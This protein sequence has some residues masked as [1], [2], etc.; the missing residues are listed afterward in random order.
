MDEATDDGRQDNPAF[1][2]NR[3]PVKVEPGA[4]VTHAGGTY[5]ISEVVDLQTVVARAIET[6]RTAVLRIGELEPAATDPLVCSSD[7]GEFSE[8]DWSVA[9]ARYETIKPLIETIPLRR[10]D[11]VNR[12]AETG[13]DPATLYRWL[14]R[15]QAVGSQLALLPKARGWRAG[16]SRLSRDTENTIDRALREHYLKYQRSRPSKTV[17]EVLRR[18]DE[19]GVTP[20]SP[21]AIRR[22]I[23]RLPE[24]EVLRG[25]GYRERAKNK[26]SPA[27]GSFP[28]ADYPLSVIQIDHTRVDIVLVDDVHRLPVKPPWITLAIDVYSRVVTGYYLSF[29]D[30]SEASVAACI[31]HSMLP[32]EEWLLLHG[33]DGDWP[34][35]GIPAKVHVDNGPDFR[36]DTFRYSCA[37]YGIDLEYRPVKQPNYGGHIE[38]LLG[39]LMREIHDL[40]GTTFSSV[41]ERGDYDSERHAVM[42]ITEFEI[43]LVNLITKIYH[44]KKHSSL[45]MTPLRQWELGIFGDREKRGVGLPARPSD[46]QT[47]VL[48]FMPMFRRTIQTF[49]VSI[50]GLTYYDEA[51]R[52][53][54][55]ESDPKTGT[56]REFIFRRDPRDISSI[57]FF[58][59]TLK[60][61]C[62]IP[63]ADLSLPSM[64]K[65]E[66]QSAKER[67]REEG[68]ASVNP[69][70]LLRAVTEM[71]A[72]VEAASEKTKK[73][74]RQAQ[75]RREHERKLS[76]VKPVAL[77]AVTQTPSP[78]PAANGLLSGD[79]NGFEDIA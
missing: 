75:R 24:R 35:W 73:A 71:R 65:W 33:C 59:P 17:I 16:K 18:C 12:S 15:Y 40:P 32:K 69:Q 1:Q 67:V 13:R 27:A 57:W 19:L 48:D 58:D 30:P 41:K 56:K 54:I 29:D 52:P 72:Q 6:G 66:Y 34:V 37:A 61:Y 46:R 8:D 7:L 38:R 23:A 43:W 53:W 2:P 31:S 74:R 45:G 47:V 21:E 76:Q 14:R 36:S 70:E 63:S 42:T 77:A 11:V 62:R 4:L 39:T 55:N 50:E 22:R 64:S 9:Q 44:R 10:A 28:G 49:G 79:I 78:P 68:A 26:F 60:R 3:R 51:L 5:R 20:P 25:R